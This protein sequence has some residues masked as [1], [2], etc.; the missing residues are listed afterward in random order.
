MLYLK[1]IYIL[2]F[3]L[4][5]QAAAAQEYR[6]RVVGIADGDTFTLLAAEKRSIKVRLAEIDTPERAQPYGSRA[7]QMLSDLLYGQEVRVVR[8]DTDRYGRLVGQVY[9]GH[10]H[11]NRQLVREGMAW[12]YRQYLKDESLL[13][14]EQQA[15][16]ARRGV[17]SLP[18]TEQVPPW[19]WRKG[20]KTVAASVRKEPEGASSF[21]C[22]GKTKC[23]EMSSCEEALFYLEHCG[24][25]R[26]D[27]DKDGIPCE[28]LCK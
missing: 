22:G 1:T 5:V 28:S 24:L 2:L 12:V 8:A 16:S 25:S 21:S 11:V 17:W 23:G 7:R 15:R 9:V 26:L 19:E 10:M 20:R 27:G 18:A 4:L 6:G 13:Q 3:M 14:D